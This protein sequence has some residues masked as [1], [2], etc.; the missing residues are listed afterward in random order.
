R[1]KTK[2]AQRVWGW[3]NG[4]PPRSRESVIAIQTSRNSQTS[5][6]VA[7]ATPCASP[8]R[9]K[10]R[11]GPVSDRS[12]RSGQ[13]AGANFGAMRRGSG[14][15]RLIALCTFLLSVS[16]CGVSGFTVSPARLTVTVANGPSILE[17]RGE[18]GPM[19]GSAGFEDLGTQDEMIALIRQTGGDVSDLLH[20]YTY[21][22]KPLHLRVLLTDYTDVRTH[23]HPSAYERPV[24]PFLEFCIYDERPGGFSY[25]ANQFLSALQERLT[26]IGTVT[27]VTP[28]PPTD[29]AEYRRVTRGIFVT[30]I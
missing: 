10:A 4:A 21:I 26:S 8:V 27:L 23:F 5:G 18:I 29:N 11:M 22:N 9:Y 1:P 13:H 6:Y 28:P 19:L 14:A 3:T 24:G 12:F 2:K 15:L 7:T 20:E 17:L 25:S 30:G 16:G